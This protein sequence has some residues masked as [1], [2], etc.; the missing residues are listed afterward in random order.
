MLFHQKVLFLFQ[1]FFSPHLKMFS[2][3]DFSERGVSIDLTVPVINMEDTGYGMRTQSID[4]VGG[5]WVTSIT[6]VPFTF[7]AVLAIIGNKGF[8]RTYIDR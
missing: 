8:Q 6:L 1:D 4:V 3:T 5:M 7:I 2:D